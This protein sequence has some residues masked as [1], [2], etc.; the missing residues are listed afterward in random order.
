MYCGKTPILP[1]RS[2]K[3]TSQLRQLNDERAAAM[4]EFVNRLA[5]ARAAYIQANRERFQTIL[6][7]ENQY[8]QRVHNAYQ[9][10]MTCEN[11]YRPRIANLDVPYEPVAEILLR[12]NELKAAEEAAYATKMGKIAHLTRELQ[13]SQTA[14]DPNHPMYETANRRALM[15]YNQRLYETQD[16]LDSFIRK[17]ERK[18]HVKSLPPYRIYVV[19]L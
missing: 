6:E 14:L 7:I 12:Q 15:W 11:K 9:S 18:T 17:Y 8:L 19:L 4:V 16:R 10:M 3:S 13:T 5:D 1:L 2:H